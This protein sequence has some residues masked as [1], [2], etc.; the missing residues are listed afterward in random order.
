MQLS[1][2]EKKMKVLEAFKKKLL[3]PP[4]LTLPWSNGRYT[5][6]PDTCNSQVECVLLQ[7]KEDKILK[8]IGYWPRSLC[9]AESRHVTT[10]KECL[11]VVRAA[12]MLIPYPEASQFMKGRIIKR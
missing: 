1:L 9:D 3:V 4:V 10:L 8:S 2:D 12:L 5:I 7:E 11:V 6:D